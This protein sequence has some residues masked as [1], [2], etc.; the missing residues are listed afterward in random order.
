VRSLAVND[1]K[2][3]T[4]VSSNSTPYQS[5]DGFFFTALDEPVSI[6]SI[7]KSA[8]LHLRT[9]T[10]YAIRNAMLRQYKCF[11]REDGL[12]GAPGDIAR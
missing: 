11:T 2:R 3:L 5:L 9:P 4:Q 12:S 1:V 8:G 7:R 6:R 10:D